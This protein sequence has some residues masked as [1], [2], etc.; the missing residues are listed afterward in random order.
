MIFNGTRNYQ[1]STKLH[2]N[3]SLIDIINV[4]NLL[5]VTI[6]SDLTWESNTK[7][8]VKGA[9]LREILWHKLFEFNMPQKLQQT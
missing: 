6:K 4:T 8:L 7:M 2:T 9:F 5:V 3:D 1:F